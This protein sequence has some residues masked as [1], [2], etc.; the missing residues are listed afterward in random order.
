MAALVLRQQIINRRWL[1]PCT[2]GPAPGPAVS[3][4]EAARVR[5]ILPKV[6]SDPHRQIRTAAAQA[7]SAVGGYDWPGRWPGLFD[8]LCAAARGETAA[9]GTPEQRR[10]MDGAMRCLSYFVENVPPSAAVASAATL[11]PHCATLA[12]AASS[13]PRPLKRRA[14]RV[15]VG[16][17]KVLSAAAH[18]G[19]HD[20]VVALVRPAVPPLLSVVADILGQ[21]S[22]GGVAVMR[23]Q[24]VAL[25]L[26]SELCVDF[27]SLV[28]PHAPGAL[29]CL[30]GFAARLLPVYVA[31][32]VE[33]DAPGAAE[34]AGAASPGSPAARAAHAASA[35][36]V[37]YD[38]DGGV[39]G[40]EVLAARTL[41][42]LLEATT[43]QDDAMRLHAR[44]WLKEVAGLALGFAQMRAADAMLWA[45]D[46][47]A[48][49]E[50]D[51]EFGLLDVK[52]RAA[53][54]TLASEMVKENGSAGLRALCEVAA[55]RA[56]P[57]AALAPGQVPGPGS[58]A[59]KLQ[60]AALL[61]LGRVGPRFTR[62]WRGNPSAAKPMPLRPEGIAAACF[63]V[64]TGELAASGIHASASHDTRAVL[65]SPP[66]P[67]AALFLR[68]RALWT[69][70]R[71]SSALSDAQAAPFIGAA[72]AALSADSAAL[73]L[74]L[75]ACKA[76]TSLS[77]QV[78]PGSA[79]ASEAMPGALAALA[80][81][82]PRVP[83]SATPTV[84]RAVVCCA[85]ASPA[86]AAAASRTLGTVVMAMW[87][88]AAHHTTLGE[89][90]KDVA[91]VLAR[92]PD[93]AVA[94]MLAERFA[95]TLGGALART[96][97]EDAAPAAAAAE[98]LR[99][100]LQNGPRP[101]PAP[102]I[103]A[104]PAI[105]AA[106][107]PTAD[108]QVRGTATEALTSFLHAA[109]GEFLASAAW[110]GPAGRSALDA[111]LEAV[112]GLLLPPDVAAGPGAELGGLHAGDV[113]MAVA[114]R[115]AA[116]VGPS[117]AAAL[118]AAVARRAATSAM[119]SVAGR[120][121]TA[122]FSF[123]SQHP[124]PSVAACASVA[125]PAPAWMAKAGLV[126][127]AG[128]PVP[129]LSCILQ[130]ACLL[131][132]H[133]DAPMAR[134]V[135]L[136]GILRILATDGAV[137]ALKDTLGPGIGGSGPTAPLPQQLTAMAALD[138]VERHAA[139]RGD[140]DGEDWGEDDVE[141]GVEASEAEAAE[142]ARKSASG[143]LGAVSVR[144]EDVPGAEDEVVDAG[145]AALGLGAFM[146]AEEALFLTDMIGADGPGAM[147]LGGGMG[148]GDSDDED[149]EAGMFGERDVDATDS[150]DRDESWA[151]EHPLRGT[152]RTTLVRQFFAA[153]AGAPGSPIATC[154]SAAM[155]GFDERLRASVLEALSAPSE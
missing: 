104:L 28:A 105:V 64:V 23:S 126:G 51:D 58:G 8:G 136:S 118:V 40:P 75:A 124:G 55:E 103:A 3:P 83:P 132:P 31:S 148:M 69:A 87:I 13:A 16:L 106:C 131:W 113:V 135:M 112:H 41:D 29:K 48:L 50:E 144:Y 78:K 93:P 143:G 154:C 84:L 24:T 59:S 52:A 71:V 26:L 101:P 129:V 5:G 117:G 115:C 62:W 72:V 122:F 85:K 99:A 91:V 139:L 35:S 66:G 65:P 57:A 60:E 100:F 7:L 32:D 151:R 56:L 146:D 22:S 79:A 88:R 130:R 111:V 141:W 34:H 107:A 140:D 116:Q 63:G 42:A 30:F 61:L 37:E 38:S 1:A 70:G 68:S 109:G 54:C 81:L 12:A 15:A 125:V 102:A 20:A 94:G 96:E 133:W 86:A 121:S 46:A 128:T 89:D 110:P 10:A 137:A 119:P 33:P 11:L 36:E 73:P 120:F 74:R 45:E 153:G 18:T 98:M 19:E 138:L 97:P 47:D 4:E 39:A 108:R 17:L 49:L 80:A 152:E 114:Q 149:G 92:N 9:G 14:V 90:L 127:A 76:L 25:A 2:D 21:P 77:R 82:L 27:S 155:G 150:D 95:P 53:A 145:S 147:G 44:P 43:S 67:D 142:A 123:C 134:T 6:L